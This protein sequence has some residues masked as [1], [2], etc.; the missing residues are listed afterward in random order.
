MYDWAHVPTRK[1]LA[2][3]ARDSF[4]TI[5]RVSDQVV[6]WIWSRWWYGSGMYDR[7]VA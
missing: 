6:V 3:Q 4:P 2:F 1:N 7:G 5:T